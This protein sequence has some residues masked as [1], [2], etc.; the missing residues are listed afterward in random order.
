MTKQELLHRLASHGEARTL[1]RKQIGALM[2]AVFQEMAQYFVEARVTRRSA[3]R[4]TYPGFGTFTKK[5]RPARTGR[6]PR[7]GEPMVIPE[8][9]TVTFQPG[10]ELRGALNRT[11]KRKTVG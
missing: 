4:F 7:T 9:V 3:P 8:Q 5:V 2:D 1:S 11:A 6:N 10:V